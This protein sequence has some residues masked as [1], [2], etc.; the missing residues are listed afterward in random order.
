MTDRYK[1]IKARLMGCAEIDDDIECIA[2]I[3]STTRKEVGADEYSDLD[4]IIVTKNTDRWL[5]GEY[6]ARLGDVSMAFCEPTLG[7]GREYRAIYG[8]DRDVDMIVFTP[9]QFDSAVKDGTAGWV[10]NRGYEILCD[11]TGFKELTAQYI[12]PVIN[13][14]KM[15]EREFT[16]MVNDFFFHNIWACKKLRRGELWSAKLCADGYLKERLLR[17]IELYCHTKN[18]ADVWHDGRFLDRW[19][20]EE[21]TCELR[22]CFAH[23]YKEDVLRALK[24]T[25]GLFAGLARECAGMLGFDYPEGAEKCA[26]QYID[27]TGET[28]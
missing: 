7:G 21:I 5:C 28:Q 25:H 20:G 6:P 26:A 1:D 12:R 19:A 3:G 16:N 11:R 22:E 2:V 27:A 9:E 18:G 4:L 8:A 13:S 10:M 15:T 17:V 24:A 23:Y 14:P